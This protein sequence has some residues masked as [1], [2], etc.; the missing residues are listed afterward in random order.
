[1]HNSLVTEYHT[2]QI[3]SRGSGELDVSQHRYNEFLFFTFLLGVIASK[4]IR[5]PP[6]DT[7]RP[8]ELRG[9]N[10]ALKVFEIRLSC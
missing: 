9:G 5:F 7:P 4:L 6:L 1:M 3:A 2:S 10:I 8:V